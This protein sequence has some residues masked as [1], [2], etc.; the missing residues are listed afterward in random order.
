MS[1]KL[2]LYNYYRHINSSDKENIWQLVG[3]TKDKHSG[4][5]K[6]IKDLQNS[7]HIGNVSSY[8]Y[9]EDGNSIY[10]TRSEK[11]TYYYI[12]ID[13]I[14]EILTTEDIINKISKIIEDYENNK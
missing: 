5:F 14:K 7:G 8:W 12:G 6:R 3:L 13:D 1:Q 4:V 2:K 10:S 11:E 9:D